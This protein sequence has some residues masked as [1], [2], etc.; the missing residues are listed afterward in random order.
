MNLRETHIG[1]DHERSQ[2]GGCGKTA[3]R[4]PGGATS[5][6]LQ[7]F[8]VLTLSLLLAALAAVAQPYVSREGRFEVDQ[9]KG[10]APLTVNITN[11]NLIT[12]GQCTGAKPC[13]MNYEGLAAVQNLFTYVFTSPGTFKMTVL[14]QNQVGGPDDITITVLPNIQPTFEI[15]TCSSNKVTIKIT[16]KNYDQYFID[17]G[18]GS[19]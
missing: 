16:D 19:A 4:N 10:C 8:T 7:A 1:C 13:A 14:Y 6:K 3:D 17:F 15:Y 12:S 18:D 11:A 2:A 5:G 9:I